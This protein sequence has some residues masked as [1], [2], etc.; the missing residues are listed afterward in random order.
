MPQL[1]H[2][3][4]PRVAGERLPASSLIASCRAPA[5]APR[6]SPRRAR[7]GRPSARAAAAARAPPSRAGDRGRA[8]ACVDVRR[9]SSSSRF[10]AATIR[11]STA[12]SDCPPTRRT[13]RVS[14]ARKQ[15][16]L[17]LDRQLADLVEEQRAAVRLDEVAVAVLDRAGERALLVTE[18]LRSRSAR[19][20]SRRSSP[21]RTGPS[22]RRELSWI[23]A[24]EQI[25]AGPGL[26]DDQHVA[27]G[28]RRAHRAARSSSRIT[29]DVAA[30]HL[31]RA[32]R[33]PRRRLATATSVVPPER[34]VRADAQLRT[35][36]RVAVDDVLVPLDFFPA[37]TRPS[38]GCR[39]GA[40]AGARCRRSSCIRVEL[41]TPMT[42]GS[43]ASRND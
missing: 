10:V 2:V 39:S 41:N 18:Q 27:I 1:A 24:R 17:Q 26:A 3:A 23:D 31:D 37:R 19:A 4:R 6:A 34:Q 20:E 8:A 25:L 15:V 13:R 35:L 11:T 30:Q 14:S 9:P 40:T 5:R 28:L 33:S 32:P 29:G 12:R 7:P 16:R 43:A 21:R 36:D 42:A 22:A 38:Q